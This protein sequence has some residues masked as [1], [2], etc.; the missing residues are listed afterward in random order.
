MRVVV[1]VVWLTLS[2]FS[3]GVSF[4]T[5]DPDVIAAPQRVRTQKS[6]RV[7]SVVQ[8]E[9]ESPPNFRGEL[10]NRFTRN[11]KKLI[12]KILDEAC[13]LIESHKGGTPRIEVAAD[14]IQNLI[15]LTR[16]FPKKNS[17]KQDLKSLH[18]EFRDTLESIERELKNQAQEYVYSLENDRKFLSGVK[19]KY[20]Q[21]L[22]NLLEGYF[23][24]QAYSGKMGG[25][26]VGAYLGP[27]IEGG[28][29]FGLAKNSLGRRYLVS[30]VR[31]AAGGIAVG[32]KAA[33]GVYQLDLKKGETQLEVRTEARLSEGDVSLMKR[34]GQPTVAGFGFGV[35]G[36][37]TSG[38]N[39]QGVEVGVGLLGGDMGTS[40]IKL[41]KARLP[42]RDTN[43]LM[44][45]LG[46]GKVPSP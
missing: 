11:E 45:T 37:K 29:H 33:L 22:V 42:W 46:I 26:N 16:E 25:I 1:L 18:I 34:I 10:H 43:G 21:A 27:G 36:S 41:K 8:E 17:L 9:I 24:G 14:F 4:A 15:V 32:A 7:R 39:I 20:D 38:K 6:Q 30:A 23:N 2:V 19:G 13:S 28:V 5:D 44:R 40:N 31:G 3:T 12:H 35:Y